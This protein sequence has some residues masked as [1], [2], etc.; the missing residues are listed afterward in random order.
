MIKVEEVINI[1][2][3]LVDKFGGKKGIRDLTLLESALNR[4]FITFDQKDLFN[5]TLEKANVL[6]NGLIQ[7]HPFIDGN[8][9]IGYFVFRAYLLS[10]GFDINASEDEKY[11]FVINI[12]NGNYNLEK[13]LIWLK[14]HII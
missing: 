10:E 3:K 5:S 8:K 7:N 1:H 6:I 12:A 13:S 14:E 11:D 2:E 4:P 9:R